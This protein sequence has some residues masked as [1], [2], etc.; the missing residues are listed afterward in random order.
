MQSTYIALVLF[1]KSVVTYT[2][3]FDVEQSVNFAQILLVN[4]IFQKG[5]QIGN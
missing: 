3:D 2:I 1:D 4:G 5:C